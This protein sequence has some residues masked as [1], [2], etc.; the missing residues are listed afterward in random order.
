MT[1]QWIRGTRASGVRRLA[2]LPS[3]TVLA[4]LSALV[5]CAGVRASDTDDPTSATTILDSAARQANVASFDHMWTTIRD[6]HWDPEL[7]GLDWEAVR[8]SL[9]PRVEAAETAA[10]GADEP[11]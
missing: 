2:A 3:M 8:D 9:R 11:G 5:G 10:G 4:A 1:R 6:K 7:G